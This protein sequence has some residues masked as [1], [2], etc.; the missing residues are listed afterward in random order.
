MVLNKSGISKDDKETVLQIE[1]YLS[2]IAGVYRAFGFHLIVCTQRPDATII[3]PLVRSNI[4]YRICGRAD[5][6]LSEIILDKP[7]ASVRVR[8][9]DRGMF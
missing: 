1:H 9:S 8:K 3:P 6:I 5:K 7:D 4:D 2:D